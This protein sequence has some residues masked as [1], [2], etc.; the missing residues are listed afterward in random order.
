M[1]QIASISIAFH[2]IIPEKRRMLHI[3]PIFV[4]GHEN[5]EQSGSH[6]KIVDRNPETGCFFYI[7]A[8]CEWKIA[9]TEPSPPIFLDLRHHYKR[10]FRQNFLERRLH[11]ISD[12]QRHIIR[13]IV[14]ASTITSSCRMWTIRASLPAQLIG[15]SLKKIFLD[16]FSEMM[17]I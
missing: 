13:D 9:I 3:N 8:L 12:N 6:L 11:T 4:S 17:M 5:L 10:Y 14:L 2:S 1:N 15:H 7:R 16:L